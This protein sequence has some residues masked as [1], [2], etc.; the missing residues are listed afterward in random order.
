M[1]TLLATRSPSRAR[2][3]ALMA[4]ASMLCVQLGL[5]VSVGLIDRVG[6]EGV[7]WLRLVWAGLLFLVIGRPWRVRFTR[8]ALS[9]AVLL[10]VATALVTLLFMAAVA[11]IPLGMAS[12]LEFL[13]PLGVAVARGRGDRR[14][15]WPLAAGVG[16]VLLTEPWS[17]TADPVGVA[18][19]L[20]AAG[21]WAAYIV[22]T[23]RV[24][25][26]VAG[27]SG[28]AISMPVAGL[29]ATLT[30]GPS[31]F[32][33]I[34]PELILIGIGLA[35]LLPI[36]PFTLELLALRRLNT[37]AFG[38]LMSLEPAFA[39]L[40]GLVIL[41]QVPGPLAV[42]GIGFVVAAGIGAERTGGREVS[43]RADDRAA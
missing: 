37:A 10:G 26:E 42:L 13:G 27:L 1:T 7:A 6:A 23:Q 15:V 38:T 9:A 16:V 39:L 11:R 22:L 20:G 30:V 21:C 31:V 5:A 14:Y 17:G 35:V 36:V 3:G 25:D 29:V 28:L 12:A 32:G 34:T 41:G 40:V 43:D 18:F 33:R 24:G 19:A 2:S 4:T 8:S